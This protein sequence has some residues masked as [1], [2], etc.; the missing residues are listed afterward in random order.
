MCRIDIFMQHAGKRPQNRQKCGKNT[1]FL[2]KVWEIL[3]IAHYSTHMIVTICA[4]LARQLI[5]S[6]CSDICYKISASHVFWVNIMLSLCCLPVVSPFWT[7]S[8]NHSTY[9]VLLP[10]TLISGFLLTVSI[11]LNW[12]F[13]APWFGAKAS[14]TGRIHYDTLFIQLGI[15][16]YVSSW[17][18]RNL[19]DSF[20]GSKTLASNI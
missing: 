3:I 16:F 9:C 12:W 13:S 8:L 15:I 10:I 6:R 11:P 19:C 2:W 20:S 17:P 14:V 5:Y 18:L 1:P 7:M 4:S